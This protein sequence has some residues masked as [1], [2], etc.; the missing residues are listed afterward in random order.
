[1]LAALVGGA[2]AGVPGALVATPLIGAAKALYLDSRGKLPPVR[3][4]PAL[5]RQ[6]KARL[7]KTRQ[8]VTDHLAEILPDRG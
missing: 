4:E 5:T 7:A 2:A 1:M 8:R 3:T 6:I